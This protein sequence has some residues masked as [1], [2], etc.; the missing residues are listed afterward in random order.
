MTA[1]LL[2]HRADGG[3]PSCVYQRA[4][5]GAAD[6]WGAAREIAWQGPGA[7]GAG[8]IRLNGETDVASHPH[9][10]IWVVVEGEVSLREPGSPARVL[11]RGEGAVIARG[12]ALQVQARGGAVVAFC[13]FEAQAGTPA[14]ITA[15]HAQA[16]F[17][18]S[19]PPAAQLLLGPT[20]QC[21]SDNVFQDEAAGVQAGTWDSTP[22]HRIVRPHP[23]NEF[24]FL[25]AGRV[26]LASPD[27]SVLE[28]GAGDAVFVPHGTAVGWESRETVAKFYVVQSLPA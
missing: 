27:G 17:K 5:F 26:R 28:A 6:P 7:M 2:L 4:A 25:L 20:P 1:A 13:A 24:M 16:D 23:V 18:P 15:L 22:Y 10:E 11:G 12:T 14:G 8:R 3:Q 9:T 19:N 21:R